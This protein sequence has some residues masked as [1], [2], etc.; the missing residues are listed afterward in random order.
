MLKLVEKSKWLTV[1]FSTGVCVCVCVCVCMHVCVH[2]CVCVCVCVYA[3][4]V[5]W[6][7]VCNIVKDSINS[8]KPAIWELICLDY[9]PLPEQSLAVILKAMS[10]HRIELLIDTI[11]T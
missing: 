1:I 2:V 11:S 6:S 3:V 4:H 8:V 10:Q 5:R 7:Y 9:G